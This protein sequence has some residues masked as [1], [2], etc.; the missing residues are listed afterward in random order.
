MSLLS[1]KTMKR[2][3][4]NSEHWL[5]WQGKAFKLEKKKREKEK[6]KKANLHKYI[7]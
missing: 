7:L 1:Y 5:Q 2:L 3:A 4:E 6:E